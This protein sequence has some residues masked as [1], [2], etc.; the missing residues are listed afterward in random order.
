VIKTC[1]GCGSFYNKKCEYCGFVDD[2]WKDS[3]TVQFTTLQVNGSMNEITI[4]YGKPLKSSY[5]ISGNMQEFFI[6]AEFV[7]IIVNGNMNEIDIDSKVEFTSIVHGNM[8]E[9]N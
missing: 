7:N 6:I 9:I 2:S 4:K 8:N 1:S 3:D 5:V